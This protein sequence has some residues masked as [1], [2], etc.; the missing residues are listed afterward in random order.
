MEEDALT[1]LLRSHGS[2]TKSKATTMTYHLM[3]Y[4][5][6]CAWIHYKNAEFIRKKKF[7]FNTQMTVRKQW[8]VFHFDQDSA[9]CATYDSEFNKK[10]ITTCSETK[11][12]NL[13]SFMIEVR[14]KYE[15][16]LHLWLHFSIVVINILL[17]FHHDWHE[18]NLKRKKT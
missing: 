2:K 17:C 11:R 5:S 7:A 6:A 18:L 3:K 15:V 14:E 4:K 1:I 10:V 8:Q 13:P 9:H 12:N 16:N